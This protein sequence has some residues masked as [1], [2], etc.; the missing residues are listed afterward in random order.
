L[1]FLLEPQGADT[2][3][4]SSFGRTVC[5]GNCRRPHEMLRPHERRYPVGSR[6]RGAARALR[7]SP[8][9]RHSS[10]V[11]SGRR[12]GDIPA[13]AQMPIGLVQLIQPKRL[14]LSWCPLVFGWWPGDANS[15]ASM[16]KNLAIVRSETRVAL[17]ACIC[18]TI[19]FAIEDSL[20]QSGERQSGS[21]RRSPGF[22]ARRK[23]E[24]VGIPALLEDVGAFG[25]GLAR[26]ITMMIPK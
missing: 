17:K 4:L 10:A 16:I 15:N 26:A 2:D 1:K 20:Q 3:C 25:G 6:R 18:L 14:K 11:V 5:F 21:V 12:P 19:L 8:A 22:S 24:R 7:P 23:Q 9:S 13:L